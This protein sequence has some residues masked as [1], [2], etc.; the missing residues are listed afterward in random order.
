MNAKV[1]LFWIIIPCDE[2]VKLS[3]ALDLASSHIPSS[4][5]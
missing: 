3:T 4:L 5:N 1:R 2:L